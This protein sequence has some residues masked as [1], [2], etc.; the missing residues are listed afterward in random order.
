MN[1]T[2][3]ECRNVKDA[4][5]TAGEESVRYKRAEKRNLVGGLN[6]EL[7]PVIQNKRQSYKQSRNV[8]GCINC[9]QEL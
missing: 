7:R 8:A 9:T 5:W 1:D 2:E 6:E 3:S 4:G